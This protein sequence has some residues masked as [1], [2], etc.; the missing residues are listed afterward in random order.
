MTPAGGLGFRPLVLVSGLPVGGAEEVTVQ[1]LRRLNAAGRPVPVC[2]VTDRH[3]GAPADELERAGVT[4]FDLGARRLAD[5]RALARLLRLLRRE[6]IDLV[7]AHGQDA[8]ILA[9]AASLLRPTSLLATRHVLE[10]PTGSV[11]ERARAS[12]ALA[13]LGR[14]DAV[15]AV[16]GAVAGRLRASR[17]VPDGRVRVIHNG[18]DL[19]RFDPTRLER[20]RPEIRNSLGVEPGARVVLL[21]AVLREGKGHD[22]LLEALPAVRERI[23]EVRLL[24][25]GAGER[26]EALRRRAR[27]RDVDDIV[28]FLGFRNDIPELL[29]ASDLV[30]L[31]SLGEAF[32][33]VLLEAAAAGRPVVATE[34]GGVP[35]VVESGRTGVLVPP[36]DGPELRRALVGILRDEDRARRFGRQARSLAQERFGIDRQVE[37]TLELWREV[38]GGGEA[39]GG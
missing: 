21:P 1:F 9:A 17:P 35:E 19:G 29:A 10:E 28:R 32:P 18:I 13:A 24:L 23:P 3:D 26:E 2:T 14:A 4:R 36:D 34:V 20:S 30:V 25:A 8:S 27:A 7:H 22:V 31:P 16:S 6:E 33:T 5:P 15:V 11:R 37:Q 38:E 39:R 12:L